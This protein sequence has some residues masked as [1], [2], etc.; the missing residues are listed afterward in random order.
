MRGSECTLEKLASRCWERAIR[1]GGRRHALDRAGERPLDR[2]RRV[3]GPE[4]GTPGEAKGPHQERGR[5]GGSGAQALQPHPD[6]DQGGGQRQLGL[7]VEAEVLHRLEVGM[8]SIREPVRPEFLQT[9]KLAGWSLHRHWT[10]SI[11]LPAS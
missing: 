5:W 8:E 10:A 6:L 2:Q 9:V 1:G 4:A 7:D 11:T 3:V